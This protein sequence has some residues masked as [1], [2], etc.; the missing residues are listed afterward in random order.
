MCCWSQGERCYRTKNITPN[1]VKYQFKTYLFISIFRSRFKTTIKL[2]KFL[3]LIHHVVAVVPIMHTLTGEGPR[4]MC[5]Y[6]VQFYHAT[7]VPWICYVIKFTCESQKS[8]VYNL[9]LLNTKST[10][11]HF[12]NKEKN[13]LFFIIH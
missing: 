8:N 13:L 7:N 12:Q 9:G 3:V 4:M 10:L 5:W 6:R 2:G 1:L 11:E